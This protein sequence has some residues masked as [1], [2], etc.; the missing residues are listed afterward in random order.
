MSNAEGNLTCDVAVIGAGT[1]GIAA[2]RARAEGRA[3]GCMA[4]YA[5]PQ[6]RLIGADICAPGGEHMAHLLVW[7]V[8]TGT[9]AMDLLSMP[10]YHPTLE[11][12]M[13][14]ALREICAATDHPEPESR[15]SGCPPGA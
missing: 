10:I 13:K 7:A 2:E 15:D 14:A 4:I 1:A 8:Q 9:T 11:E 3:Q 5:D 6:G 12:G